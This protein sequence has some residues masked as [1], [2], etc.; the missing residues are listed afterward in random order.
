MLAAVAA[1]DAEHAAGFVVGVVDGAGFAGGAVD[2]VDAPMEADR[3]GAVAGGGELGFPAVEVVAGSY[4]D[5]KNL[6]GGP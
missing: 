1:R 5:L 2:G 3:R 4:F 6:G